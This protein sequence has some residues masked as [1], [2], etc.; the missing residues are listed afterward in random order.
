LET[1]VSDFDMFGG[2]EPERPA[3]LEEDTPE[4]PSPKRKK[5]SGKR[6]GGFYNVV[7]ALFIGGAI[8][9][10][11]LVVLV[12][13]NPNLPFNPFPPMTLAPTPTLF[14][15]GGGGSDTTSVP[16][17]R[18]PTQPPLGSGATT[19]T[20][21]ITPTGLT[22]PAVNTTPLTSF[23]FTIQNEAVTYSRHPNGCTGLWLVGQVFNL[24]NEP[25]VCGPLGRPL[26]CLPVQV[27]GE[28][29]STIQFTGSAPDWGPSGYEVFLNSTPVEAEFEVQLLNTNGQPLSEPIVV[30]TLA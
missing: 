1:A 23:P 28:E 8:G 29:F 4:P 17:T 21:G 12:A 26:P 27:N 7:A 5:P 18:I 6:G 19:P 2:Y 11:A 22:A 30:R 24:E 3:T 10:I 13:Q 15:V 9:M 25:L 16:A 20:A 14:V